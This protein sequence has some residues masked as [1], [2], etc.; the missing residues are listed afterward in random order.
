MA[1]L[2]HILAL[3]LLVLG[4]A[5]LALGQDYQAGEWHLERKPSKRLT[6]T[7]EGEIRAPKVE[8]KEWILIAAR[9]PEHSLSAPRKQGFATLVEGARPR[10]AR[11]TREHFS[12]ELFQ[13]RG[14]TLPQ[15]ARGIRY[16][17]RCEVD[18]FEVRLVP[19][20]PPGPV[21]TPRNVDRFLRS[22]SL[23]ALKDARFRGWLARA[24]LQRKAGERDLAFAFR[25]LEAIQR[26]FRY[27]Y[28]PKSP[29]RS[30]GEVAADKASDCGGLSGLAVAALRANEIP[31]RLLVGRWVTPNEDEDQQFHVKFEFFAE[32]I[33]WVPCDGSG[34]VSWEGGAR[35]A[36][37][38]SRGSFLVLHTGAALRLDSVHWGKQDADFLQGVAWWVSGEGSVEG[39][40]HSARWI[41]RE[42]SS[43]R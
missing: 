20:A 19:G 33:G 40:T 24:K 5:H 23:H 16:R 11:R 10:R 17:L 27:A 2:S 36:F 39:S 1:R 30:C 28:P 38:I 12:R 14:A 25:V 37:G 4:A 41:V 32:G 35:A 29:Q 6:A 43:T 9:A 13:L 8:A 7:L 31:A 18:T 21:R 26:G 42:R 15:E 34:A 22:T 3:L